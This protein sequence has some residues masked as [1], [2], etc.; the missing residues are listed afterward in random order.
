MNKKS[1]VL[2][3]F[4]IIFC[5]VLIL[6]G[7]LFLVN[8]ISFIDYDTET[9][10]TYDE[11]KKE[12]LITALGIRYKMN[13]FTL[14]EKKA[15]EKFDNSIS[16]L[17]LINIERIFPNKV[18]VTVLRRYPLYEINYNDKY[19]TID[20]EGVVIRVSEEK[21][22]TTLVTGLDIKSITPGLIITTNDY[23][24]SRLIAL[25]QACELYGYKNAD[26]TQIIERIDVAGYA[27]SLQTKTG[28]VI[29]FN[30]A[31]N[32]KQKI[33]EVLSWYNSTDAEMRRYSGILTVYDDGQGGYLRPIYY[34]A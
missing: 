27:F 10:Y 32:L 14:S 8:D 3:V 21:T 12:E 2:F 15:V 26:F 5:T 17:K 28:V 16:S 19:Y 13:I 7:T 29:K 34:P 1:I 20:R 18:K 33:R 23:A 25:G 4:L 11:Y 30:V 24:A 9:E 22:G 31:T 6:N